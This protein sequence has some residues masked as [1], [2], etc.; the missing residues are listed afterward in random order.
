MDSAVFAGAAV[1]YRVARHSWREGKG[2]GIRNLCQSFL[3]VVLPTSEIGFAH[4]M[5]CVVVTRRV[6][7]AACKLRQC[8]RRTTQLRKLM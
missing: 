2:G 1:Y 8:S 6:L 3:E 5:T 4:R 7:E